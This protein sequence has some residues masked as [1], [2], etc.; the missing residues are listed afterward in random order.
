MIRESADRI[1][2]PVT[3]EEVKDHCGYN[4]ENRTDDGMITRHITAMRTM[5][6]GN[7]DMYIGYRAVELSGFLTIP[8]E[9]PYRT[10]LVE[11]CFYVDEDGVLQDVPFE[12][13]GTPKRLFLHPQPETWEQVPKLRAVVRVGFQDCPE[14]IRSA[15]CD[16]VKAKIE[17]AE[18]TPVL[19]DAM[20]TLGH[21][22]RYRI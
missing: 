14:D 9:L 7:L 11:K 10:D 8:M 12:I 19:E 21:Y 13:R 6:E 4:P 1:I 18:L 22:R 17:R 5:L 2:E 3:L 16:M 15:I 20:S